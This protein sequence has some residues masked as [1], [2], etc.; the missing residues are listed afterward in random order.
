MNRTGTLDA[1]RRLMRC[2]NGWEC[3]RKS[4]DRYRLSAAQRR[5][6]LAATAGKVVRKFEYRSSA[7]TSPGIGGK[8]LWELVR[9]HLI[10]NG[11][12]E[13]G[14]CVMLLT[15]KGNRELELISREPPAADDRL[16]AQSRGR[17]NQSASFPVCDRPSLLGC[18][19]FLT[20]TIAILWGWSDV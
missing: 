2:W 13:N 14:G 3:R 16:A 20:T 4:A 17:V 9:N 18:T 1:Q 12:I 5:A 11:P 19:G 6:L 15:L 10:E 7:L 8:A